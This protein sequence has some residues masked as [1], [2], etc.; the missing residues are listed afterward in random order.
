SRRTAIV[1]AGATAVSN[2]SRCAPRPVICR[3]KARAFARPCASSSPRWATV[4]WTTRRPRRTER[5]RRQYVCAFRPFRRTAYRRYTRLPPPRPDPPG[6]PR[7]SKGRR[8]ALHGDSAPHRR[9]PQAPWSQR[10]ADFFFAGRSAE[11]GLAARDARGRVALPLLRHRAGPPH[12]GRGRGV[13]EAERDHPRQDESAR[14][15]GEAAGESVRPLLHHAFGIA[16]VPAHRLQRAG[17]AS[18]VLLEAPEIISTARD[19]DDGA[20]SPRELECDF[21]ADA[22]RSVGDHADEPPVVHVRPL[23]GVSGAV[24]RRAAELADSLADAHPQGCVCG[25]RRPDGA[26]THAH[27]EDAGAPSSVVPVDVLVEVLVEVVEDEVV[28]VGLG[29]LV[30]VDVV[31]L[32]LVDSVEEVLVLVLDVLVELLV[33]VDVVALVLVDSVDDVLVDAVLDVVVLVPVTE[34]DVDVEVDVVVD[35]AAGYAAGGGAPCALKRACESR[36]T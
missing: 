28:E 3:A 18:R 20:P 2:S 7:L 1:A 31:V 6:Y 12:H 19:A 26:T 11:V 17:E 8:S 35:S 29:V 10:P 34:L 4:S 24:A 25:A 36:L 14:Q 32:V 5:T 22:A 23:G 21:P 27:R 9:K 30:D 15:H 33:D 16:H 13:T